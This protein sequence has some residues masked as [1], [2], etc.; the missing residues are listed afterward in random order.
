[1]TANTN[2]KPYGVV[3]CITNTVNGKKYIGQTTRSLKARWSLHLTSESCSLLRRAIDKHGKENFTITAIEASASKAELDA[4]ECR[5]IAALDTLNPAVGYNLKDG[6]ESRRYSTPSRKKM[7]DAAKA[8]LA[9]PEA[10]AALSARR[11]EQCAARPPEAQ[12]KF[13]GHTHSEESRA[14]I[15]ATLRDTFSS[16]EARKKL[17]DSKVKLWQS[18]EYREKLSKARTGLKHNEETLKKMSEA[19]KAYW[20]AKKAAQT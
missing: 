5:H 6:G 4:A 11:K 15:A 16:E 17:S 7:S 18:A 8:R 2:S 20:A 13:A 1:M 14:K 3:Y 10:R 12:A 19:R 9:T